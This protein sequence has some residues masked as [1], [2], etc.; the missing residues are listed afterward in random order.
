ME[1]CLPGKKEERQNFYN[2]QNNFHSCSGISRLILFG[3]QEGKNV[4]DIKSI[5]IFLHL[6]ESS[7]VLSR[8]RFAIIFK[9]EVLF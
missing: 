2:K 1:R 3:S 9:F 8:K 5:S 4:F 7:E 6:R